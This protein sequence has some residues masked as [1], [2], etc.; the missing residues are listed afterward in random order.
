MINNIQNKYM[1]IADEKGQISFWEFETE[2]NI[3]N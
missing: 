1:I 2:S 3:Y